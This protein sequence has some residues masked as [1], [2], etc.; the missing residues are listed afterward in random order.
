MK[1]E[2][3]IYKKSFTGI[4][5]GRRVRGKEGFLPSLK[6]FRPP[7]LASMMNLYFVS[8]Y[9]QQSVE[10]PPPLYLK[11]LICTCLMCF[12]V[13]MCNMTVGYLRDGKQQ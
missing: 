5:Q 12:Y 7:C 4:F 3:V 2:C 11:I 8:S 9:T 10:V 1:F 13:C 6:S